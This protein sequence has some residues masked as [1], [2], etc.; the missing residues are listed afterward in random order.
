M[1]P[2]DLNT[3]ILLPENKGTNFAKKTR[4]KKKIF[5]AIIIIWAVAAVLFS[6]WITIGRRADTSTVSFF[7]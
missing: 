3:N 1:T 2:Y 4:T 5:L 7:P 6:L